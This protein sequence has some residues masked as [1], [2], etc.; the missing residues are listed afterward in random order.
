MS[1]ASEARMQM[2]L[3]GQAKERAGPQ[4]EIDLGF[5]TILWS[6][7]FRI[8]SQVKL[9]QE[10]SPGTLANVLSHEFLM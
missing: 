3:R 9:K 4:R 10:E 7:L 5:G 8:R 2:T 6:A 1:R